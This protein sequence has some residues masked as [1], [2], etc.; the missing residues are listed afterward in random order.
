MLID[1]SYVLNNPLFVQPVQHISRTAVINLLGENV[2]NEC[3]V[4]TFASVQPVQSK[5]L[6]RIPEA[7]RTKNVQT[8]FLKGKIVTA[9]PGLYSD[10]LDFGGK[11]FT[12]LST[13]DWSTYGT[14]W[15]E[16]LCVALETTT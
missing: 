5:E 12:V 3:C 7:F 11:K 13:N 1:I 14:G 2:I 4:D 8:F 15:S 10:V 6:Q 16:G 9:G